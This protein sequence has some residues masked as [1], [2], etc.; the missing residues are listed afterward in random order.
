VVGI[1]AINWLIIADQSK[2][3]IFDEDCLTLANLHSDA[4]DYPKSG[5]PVSMKTI[6]KLKFPRRPDWNAPET[7]NT[8]ENYY[9]SHRAI[10][11]LFRAIDLPIETKPNTRHPRSQ[12]KAKRERAEDDL[13]ERF[14]YFDLDGAREDPVFDAVED[15]VQDFIDT[16]G[17]WEQSDM[18]MISQLFERYTSELRGICAASTLSHARTA[19][20]SEEEAIIGTIVQKSSQPRKRKDMMSSLR[21][22]TDVLVRAIREE[23]SGDDDPLEKSLERAWI[24]WQLSCAAGKDFGAQSFGWVALGAIFEAIRQIDEED[25]AS[26][27][28]F[29]LRS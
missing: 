3:G 17:P 14:T 23:L 12:K 27:R 7:V 1:V 16:Y 15:R 28:R 13:V 2:E 11:R 19:S 29:E 22:S 25:G 10:G 9:P 4:V 8:T 21:E 24:A 18:D 20:L 6:P 5:Q 26:V